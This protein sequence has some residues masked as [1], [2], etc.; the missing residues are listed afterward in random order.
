LDPE[1]RIDI[2]TR[3]AQEIVT[4]E[5]LRALL[6]TEAK[7]KAYWGFESSGLMHIGMGSVCGSKIKDMVNAGFE[8]TIFLADW[9]SWINN[10]LGGN[11][12]N[13]R[14]C[15]EYFKECFTALGIKPE[16]VRYVWASDLAKKIEYWEKVVRIAKSVSI[17]RTWRALP[18]MGREMSLT[19]METAWVYY[20][21]MQ[22]ADIFHMELQVVCAGIDQRKAHM[23]ARDAAEKL[24]WKKPVCIHTPLLMGLQG[25]PL[26]PSGRKEVQFDEEKDI[27]LQIS[28]KMAKSK[29]ES[30][31]FVHDTPSDI[32]TKIREAFC[33]PRQAEGNPVM[34]IAKHSIFI[35]RGLLK[36]SRPTKYGGS[37][38]FNSYEE[39]EKA[40]VGRK[41]HPLDLKE[42]VADALIEILSPV[43]E[44]FRRHPKSLKKMKQIEVSR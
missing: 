8:F 17:Q 12:E 35:E 40:Y 21:C 39:L 34:E 42:G 5:E 19:D 2:V 7:P 44:Y 36:I 23:L 4:R 1:Q 25:P 29:P 15:G 33:P 22:A 38:T 32:K 20:P 13:I 30:C 9:H 31:I 43:R 27:N 14:L 18:I 41:L 6:E 37:E 16:S 26:E 3:N 10:K 24:G 11:M 28:S